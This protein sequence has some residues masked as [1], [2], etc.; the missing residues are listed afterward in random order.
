MGRSARSVSATP[1]NIVSIVSDDLGY[2]D[3]GVQG[4]R[5]IPTPRNDSIARTRPEG[6]WFAEPFS[7]TLDGLS[8]LEYGSG[9][10]PSTFSNA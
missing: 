10:M 1:P 7:M 3:L 5:D 9:K 8:Y 2:A 6:D 4:C